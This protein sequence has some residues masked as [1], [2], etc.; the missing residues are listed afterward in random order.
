MMRSY[1]LILSSQ[2]RSTPRYAFVHGKARNWPGRIQGLDLFELAWH[3]NG[4]IV[5][6]HP[7]GMNLV[8]M[9]IITGPSFRSAKH[10]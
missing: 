2:Q 9:T 3:L 5:W 10:A 8:L 4:L 7:N 6:N 1:G